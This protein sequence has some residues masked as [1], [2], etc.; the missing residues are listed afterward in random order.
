MLGAP[1]RQV[2]D[3]LAAGDAGRDDLGLGGRG[4][5]RG[6]QPAIAER[7]GDVVVLALEAE[8]SGHAAAAGVDLLDLEARPAKRRNR[9]RRADERLL[10]AMAVEQRLLALGAECQGQAAAALADQELL[11]QER[12]LRD[13]PGVVGAHEVDRLVAQGQEAR[14]LEPDD[15]DAP[16][17]VRR[18]ALDVPEGVL[19]RLAEHALGDE[20]PPA[21]LAVDE[22]DSI[23]RR[24]QDT[25]RRPRD[26]RYVVR[27]E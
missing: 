10:V 1:A 9:G 5:H 15:R 23:S 27:R 17:R 18:Q 8:R 22:Y 26:L 19:A 11:E 13:R 6:R 12:L 3:L 16:A 24:L 4:L 21:A 20:R 25:H 2:L 7:D 14:G